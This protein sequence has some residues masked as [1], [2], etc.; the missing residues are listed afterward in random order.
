MKKIILLFLII[1][2]SINAQ[3]FIQTDK[4]VASDRG[5]GRRFGEFNV[6]ISG[7]TAIVGDFRR[8]SFAGAVFI[9]EK[10]D[11]GN[12]QEVQILAG[13]AGTRFGRSCAI[14]GSYLVVGATSDATDATGANPLANAGAAF[15]YTK[16]SSGLWVLVNKI[17]SS[18]RAASQFFGVAV[19]ITD[20]TIAVGNFRDSTDGFSLNGSVELYQKQSSG[21]WTHLQKITAP[22]KAS[23]R[24]FG[25]PLSISG[26]TLVASHNRNDSR[27][28]YVFEKPPFGSS[29]Q[30]TQQ[31]PKGTFQNFGNRLAVSGDNMVFTSR[32]QANTKTV[33]Q[34]YQ[35][36]SGGNWSLN[37]NHDINS[38]TV[39]S[40]AMDGV[41]AIVGDQGNDTDANNTTTLTDAGAAFYYKLRWR[42]QTSP[43]STNNP[44]EWF[45]SK[46][47]TPN[48]RRTQD[49]F[50]RAVAINGN[51]SM[52]SAMFHDFDENESNF[53]SE[54]G[55][56]YFFEGGNPGGISD[57]LAIWLK[58]DVDVNTDA[59]SNAI[60]W[61]DQ[62]ANLH[63][64]NGQ[65]NPIKVDNAINFNPAIRSPDDKT[66]IFLIDF[67]AL[68]GSDYT[69]LAIAK[70]NTNAN[71]N[72]F[73]GTTGSSLNRGLHLGYRNNTS[74][75]LAHF[76]NDLDLPVDEYDNPAI[77][78]VLV[79]GTLDQT[80]GRTLRELKDGILKSTSDTS[81][82]PL[83]GNS[84]GTLNG[85]IGTGFD[86]DGFDGDIAEVIIYSSTLT[87]SELRKINSYL[88]IKYGFTL[89]NASGGTNGDY[90]ASNGTTI[91]W[92]ASSNA[93]YHNNIIALAKDDQ[94]TLHQTKSKSV[95][96][97]SILTIEKVGGITNNRNA[98]VMGSTSKPATFTNFTALGSYDLLEKSWRMQTTGNI[99]RIT[100]SF[101]VPNNTGNP[102]DYA[103]II[104]ANNAD[105]TTGSSAITTATI[106]G[107]EITFTNITSRNGA[108]YTLGR[109]ATDAPGGVRENIA[110]WV[111][112]GVN[113]INN[114][115]GSAATNGETV[116]TWKDD[117]NDGT[118]TFVN[119]SLQAPVLLDNATDNINYNSVVDFS[120]DSKGMYINNS[121]Y[122]FS[123]GS[124]SQDGFTFFSI[125][126]PTD[127]AS[128]KNQ[129]FI[130]DFGN[131]S[132]DGYGFAYGDDNLYMYSSTNFG[133]VKSAITNHSNNTN[134]S[135]TK[136]TI[137]FN[138]NQTVHLN[139]NPIPLKTDAI[140]LSKLTADEINEHPVGGFQN[141]AGAFT[142]G[143]QSKQGGFVQ[144]NNRSFDGKIAEVIGYR[145]VL[146][147]EET[148]RIESYL[149]IKYALTL[150]NSGSVTQGDY[151]DSEGNIIWDASFNPP[152][153]N[154]IIGIGRDE[155]QR[156]LQKQSHTINDSIRVYIGNLAATNSL[157]T[158]T[159]SS[160]KSYVMVGGSGK[161]CATPLSNSE[162]PSVNIT[163]MERELKVTKS[164]FDDT[165]SID[166]TMA[167]C[168]N[169]IIN[170]V[171]LLVDTDSNFDNGN[172]TLFANGD[173]GLSITYNA[174]VITVSGIS[175]THIPNNSIRWITLSDINITL[176]NTT[177][178]DATLINGSF[179]TLGGEVLG[180]GGTSV[181]ER[182]IVYSSTNTNP[183]IGGTAVIQ[184]ENGTN[185]GPF[186]EVITGL[187]LSTTYYYRSYAINTSGIAYGEVKSFTTLANNT[188]N[189]SS[190]RGGQWSD[191]S[192][193]SLGRIPV[194]TDNVV[195]TSGSAV[196]VD[197]PNI[198]V[199]D[200]T[201]LGRT[202]IRTDASITV[203]G[204]FS[205]SDEFIITSDENDSGVL[206]VKGSTTGT[207][208]YA[209]GG[210]LANRWSL[211]SPVVQNQLIVPFA[212]NAINNIRVNTAANPDRYA[213]GYYESLN[214]PGNRWQYFNENTNSS[215]AF[216]VGTGYIVSRATDGAVIFTGN[217]HVDD[218][219]KNVI[220]NQWN[221]IGNSFAAYYPLNKNSGNNFLTENASK[222][223][224][225]AAYTWDNSQSKYVATTN[226]VTSTEKFLPPGQGFF[227]RPNANTT[228]LF[229][230]Q[231]R[232]TKPS[233]G[234]HIFAKSSATTPFIKLSVL[235]D[236]TTVNTD[237]I[238]SKTAT[239]G[240]DKNED[241]ENFNGASFDV[242]THLIENSDGKNY[243][244]QS[245][246]FST[247]E[248][249]IIPI[250]I[251]AKKDKDIIFSLNAVD[252]PENIDIYLEDKVTNAFKKLNSTKETSYAVTL[253]EDVN[254]IGRFYV[255]TL[256]KTLKNSSENSSSIQ[257]IKK[258][259]N[260]LSITG[261]V[262][263][264]AAI[265]IYNT[266]GKEIF[267]TS[268]TGKT[269]NIIGLPDIASGVYIVKVISEKRSITKKIIIE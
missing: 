268:I 230:E 263:Q 117:S 208:N 82:A 215:N 139:S 24:F 105:F 35:K 26:N 45:F 95:N 171:R 170:K 269:N 2:S 160:N 130:Y 92:D 240:F 243:T 161:L 175:S 144:N 216:E 99:G 241:I 178:A 184:N 38:L 44:S 22:D 266:L 180:L 85:V 166:F 228:L 109:V 47:I 246:P 107:D 128:A 146:N 52:V 72:Y 181:T 189:Y 46:K 119:G 27:G 165:F 229:D 59:N 50:G 80:I 155:N 156:L 113:S 104:N 88:A 239:K 93:T 141:A 33:L 78:P 219:N 41:N 14:H 227:V 122:I 238:F 1:S 244:I 249:T 211:V 153:H 28:V 210:L 267:K 102:A 205:N 148:K 29:W 16:N 13:A 147:A 251:T 132:G 136:H 256:A 96:T 258:D 106:S 198:E 54:S 193:W 150:D 217:L 64:A 253:Q 235:G 67:N 213:I 86:F 25:F 83:V 20:T 143:R 11:V 84:S 48:I 261:I 223:V 42:E 188:N 218:I 4:I 58:A 114:A 71:K 18:T 108:Y 63:I 65:N 120:G 21:N 51:S 197:L 202:I 30:F 89:P 12:W 5:A 62:S 118:K 111:K 39:F 200:L 97:N 110:L 194:T 236:K 36:D 187:N 185:L 138:D 248:S 252:F 142:I 250:H 7:N 245:L 209:R 195:I 133:G 103:L 121:N 254:S 123:N 260:H 152:S 222:L 60:Q 174:P 73:L 221:A 40:V 226:L 262:N 167:A 173:H 169:I 151:L 162:V 168:A 234:T 125:V 23:N 32:D 265:N 70:R 204:D 34:F 192:K 257:L 68:I 74:L 8:N 91:F 69:I 206:L 191:V 233:S 196:S 75:A 37:A 177:T 186:S 207:I 259:N 247:I 190:I 129:Q 163:R 56:A 231:K 154:K 224:I 49:F 158:G 134:T 203:N 9:Y 112:P 115:S 19:D 57:N 101:T 126:K 242:N 127:Q 98:V 79:T 172:T 145:K 81:T 176:A 131:N 94:S 225:P 77:V 183:T 264:K 66:T 17:V 76:G 201:V 116:E 157:N 90:I 3:N 212:Q 87:N 179:A 43:L 100:M 199:N 55:A 159:F 164:N 149:A 255:H 137:D 15:V 140:T 31:I 135:L 124:G 53:L 10:D 61:Q 6:D 182:G 232:S 214:A 220:G 237:I